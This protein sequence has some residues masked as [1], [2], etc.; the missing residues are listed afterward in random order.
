MVKGA[1]IA[2]GDRFTIYAA[3][4]RFRL[5]R[6]DSPRCREM[7]RA[8]L[9]YTHTRALHAAAPRRVRFLR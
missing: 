7:F 3:A 5:K 4:V 1:E 6:L 9:P 2:Q 8:R